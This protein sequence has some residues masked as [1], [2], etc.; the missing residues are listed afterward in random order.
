[1]KQTKQNIP[2]N[3]EGFNEAVTKI[4]SLEQR[5]GH[6]EDNIKKLKNNV[7]SS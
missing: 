6:C 1:M 5:I 7:A 3:E 4:N 2:F